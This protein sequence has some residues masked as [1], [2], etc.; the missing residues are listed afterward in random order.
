VKD[1]MIGARLFSPKPPHTATQVQPG[2]W[3]VDWI[4]GRTF[5][6][7]QAVIALVVADFLA[8]AGTDPRR[9]DESDLGALNRWAEKLGLLVSELL[10]M[11]EVDTQQ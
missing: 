6:R 3:E 10:T 2:E 1:T 5:T 8:G 4:P 9:M 7:N 11:F